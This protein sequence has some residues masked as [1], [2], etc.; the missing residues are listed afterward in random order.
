MACGATLKRSLEFDP[1]HSPGRSPKRLCLPNNLLSPTALAKQQHLQV[2]TTSNPVCDATHKYANNQFMMR[3]GM[4]S[5]PHSPASRDFSQQMNVSST[6]VS[7][8][9][10]L[11]SPMT[12]SSTNLSVR[13]CASLSTA[14]KEQP[15]FT[16]SQVDTICRRIVQEHEDHVRE[17][18]DRVLT[19]KISEQYESFLKFNHE[20]LKRRFEREANDCSYVSWGKKSLSSQVPFETSSCTINATHTSMQWDLNNTQND[21]FLN[22][23]FVIF[24]W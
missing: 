21:R 3:H 16:L 14:T 12:K 23:N 18:F 20:Q 15:L 7:T 19:H 24:S 10:C 17:Q 5:P 4:W 1:V 11:M 8:S 9:S 13:S 2:A 22:H 6:A